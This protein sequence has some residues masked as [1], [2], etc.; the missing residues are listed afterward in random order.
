MDFWGTIIIL[1]IITS[2]LVMIIGPIMELKGKILFMEPKNPPKTRGRW[3]MGLMLVSIVVFF[4]G[5][6]GR[7]FFPSQVVTPIVLG[8][9]TLWFVGGIVAVSRNE[10]LKIMVTDRKESMQGGISDESRYV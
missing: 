1:S 6:F 5:L 10:M 8:S 4:G 3:G 7:A 9:Y 2:A